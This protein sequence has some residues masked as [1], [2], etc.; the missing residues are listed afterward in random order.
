MAKPT[1]SILCQELYLLITKLFVGKQFHY[2][3]SSSTS[4]YNISY[5]YIL[6]L[7]HSSMIKIYLGFFS[8]L[9]NINKICVESLFIF[10]IL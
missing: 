3:S 9:L 6:I 1:L 2:T 5:M 7:P 8:M 4:T 10:Y